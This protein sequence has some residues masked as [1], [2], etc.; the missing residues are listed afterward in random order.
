M[1]INGEYPSRRMIIFILFVNIK[2]GIKDKLKEVQRIFEIF[3]MLFGLFYSMIIISYFKWGTT[4]EDPLIRKSV[5]YFVFIMYGMFAYLIYYFVFK[6]GEGNGL[7]MVKGG[8]THILKFLL[9]F[10]II[11]IYLYMGGLL[12]YV[13]IKLYTTNTDRKF[14][15]ASI[16]IWGISIFLFI[17]WIISKFV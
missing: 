11:G 9:L 16:S 5:T 3:I 10:L 15:E 12:I 13:D 17:A 1:D 8:V 14:I 6:Q 4:I 2:M 7:G